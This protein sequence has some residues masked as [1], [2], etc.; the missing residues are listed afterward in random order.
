MIP[1]LQLSAVGQRA[2]SAAKDGWG[3]RL[4]FQHHDCDDHCR[5]RR[6]KRLPVVPSLVFYESCILPS[7]AREWNTSGDLTICPGRYAVRLKK[8][9]HRRGDFQNVCLGSK[10]AGIQELDLRLR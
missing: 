9:S 4:E 7:S 2:K 1:P 5:T 6:P 10:V 8:L 3:R